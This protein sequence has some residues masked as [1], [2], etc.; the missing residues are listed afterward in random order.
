MLGLVGLLA[1]GAILSVALWWTPDRLG[2]IP[3]LLWAL[4]GFG[5]FYNWPS[6]AWLLA[7]AGASLQQRRSTAPTPG[8]RYLRQCSWGS[9]R[10]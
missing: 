3:V 10:T 6:W 1:I 8:R 4:L 5:V 7:G 9:G 2:P